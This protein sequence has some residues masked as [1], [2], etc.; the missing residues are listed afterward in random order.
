MNEIAWFY[1]NRAYSFAIAIIKE[2]AE[3]NKNN[4]S[5]PFK[6]KQIFEKR[7]GIFSYV[8]DSLHVFVFIFRYKKFLQ[9][10]H[11]SYTC[12]NRFE[13]TCSRKK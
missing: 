2:N 7:M 8:I 12:I 1:S 13:L 9:I 4:K 10:A 11:N 6:N 5:I 3:A